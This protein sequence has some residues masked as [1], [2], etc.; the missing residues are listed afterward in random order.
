MFHYDPNLLGFGGIVGSEEG[1]GAGPR[2]IITSA[3]THFSQHR[4]RVCLSRQGA[5]C[6]I[7]F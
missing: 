1:Q 6:T 5:A 3:E 7:Y 4:A 2:R